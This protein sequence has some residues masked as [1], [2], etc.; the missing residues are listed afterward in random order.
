MLS[1]RNIQDWGLSVESQQVGSLANN[2]GIKLAAHRVDNTTIVLKKLRSRG[3]IKSFINKHNLRV[4]IMASKGWNSEKNILVIESDIYS[5]E[6]KEWVRSTK[7]NK[8]KKPSDMEVYNSFLELVSISENKSS[9]LI[10]AGIEFYSPYHAKLWLEWLVIDLNEY[11]REQDLIR[12]QGR[13]D[14]LK[15]AIDEVVNSSMN[16]VFL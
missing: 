12:A 3:F 11:I 16:D 10:T 9:G 6:K 7:L 1:S 13:L 8:E 5:I 15:K 4:P 2:A 14:Y